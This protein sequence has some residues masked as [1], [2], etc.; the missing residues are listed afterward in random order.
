MRI[1]DL[2]KDIDVLEFRAPPDQEI[3]DICYDSRRAV[4]NSLFVAVRGLETDGHKF[5]G[6]ALKKR[7]RLPYCAKK[8]RILTVLYPDV[9][10][11]ICPC[12]YFGEL[13]GRPAD[14]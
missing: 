9:R 14:R 12:D 5:I 13:F 10:Y 6:D 2:L 8:S 7:V 11:A 3:T 4:K 1:R